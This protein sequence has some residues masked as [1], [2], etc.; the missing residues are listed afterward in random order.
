MLLDRGTDLEEASAD[1]W[2]P[3]IWAV[4]QDRPD[5]LRALLAAGAD[6]NAPVTGRNGWTPLMHAIHTRQ[7]AESPTARLGAIQTLLDAGADPNERSRKGGTPLIM[8]AGYGATDMVELLLDA[9]A[10]PRLQ[11]PD[12]GTA[13]TAAVGGTG[14]LDRFTLGQCQTDTVEAILAR[15]PDLRL[16]TGCGTGW[17]SDWRAGA[18]APTWCAWLA[19]GPCDADGLAPPSHRLPGTCGVSAGRMA[20]LAA[21]P[22]FHHALRDIIATPTRRSAAPE[23]VWL[24]AAR[25]TAHSHL[26][27]RRRPSSGGRRRRV[28]RTAR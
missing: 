28:A 13:L 2:R 21:T 27:M 17:H 10:D 4:R 23:S 11:T 20:G 1:G 5:I 18:G 9:G 6:P 16:V 25:G 8:A 22:D 7:S 14:D 3:V 26:A 12:G 19:S 24:P 15:A